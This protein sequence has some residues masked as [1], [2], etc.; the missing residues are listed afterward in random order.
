MELDIWIRID[1]I[2]FVLILIHD[3]QDEETKVK[4]M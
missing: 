4:F 3:F 2:D 1:S